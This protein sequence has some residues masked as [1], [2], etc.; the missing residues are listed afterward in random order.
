MTIV[1]KNRGYQATMHSGRTQ[2]AEIQNE[3]SP[4]NGKL[5]LSTDAVSL[6]EC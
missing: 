4:S 1:K 3:K 5:I 2:F 6:A